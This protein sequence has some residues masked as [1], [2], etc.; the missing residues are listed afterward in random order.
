M[1]VD[2]APFDALLDELEAELRAWPG[3]SAGDPPWFVERIPAVERE[4]STPAEWHV[5]ARPSCPPTIRIG[6]GWPAD[7]M[8]TDNP[9]EPDRAASRTVYFRDV[10]VR[11]ENGQIRVHH[12]LPADVYDRT[13]I[14][15]VT[16]TIRASLVRRRMDVDLELEIVSEDATALVPLGPI[17]TTDPA[18]RSRAHGTIAEVTRLEV[19]YG[20]GWIDAPDALLLEVRPGERSRVRLSYSVIWEDSVEIEGGVVRSPS[21]PASVHGTD[22]DVLLMIE[23]LGMAVTSLPHAPARGPIGW[24]TQRLRGR[25]AGDGLAIFSPIGPVHD[26]RLSSGATLRWFGEAG[27]CGPAIAKALERLPAISELPDMD[28]YEST[29]LDDTAG[30]HLP[31]TILIDRAKAAA[32]CAFL[33]NGRAEEDEEMSPLHVLFHEVAHAWFGGMV[34]GTNLEMASASESLAEYVAVSSLPA[35]A[36]ARYRDLL[37]TNERTDRAGLAQQLGATSAD[38]SYLDGP[39][40]L[41]TIA[42]RIGSETMVEVLRHYVDAH[43]GQR[44]SWAQVLA[45]IEAVAGADVAAWAKPLIFDPV[46]PEIR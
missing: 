40:V 26:V 45:S 10:F 23:G 29:L 37:A 22:V 32:L 21:M 14:R 13:T 3:A 7:L 6:D 16:G 17:V 39:M 2:R 12:S 11:R 41:W 46:L 33:E 1:R 15:S 38:L 19:P 43:R 27:R 30:M 34:A 4:L 31:G 18:C 25:S 28:V 8:I 44:G 20:G 9:D 36:V 24:R 35:D 5:V 42:D